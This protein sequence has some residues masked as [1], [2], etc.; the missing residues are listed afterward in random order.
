ME[1]RSIN[2][3]LPQADKISK[4]TND[5]ALAIV[6]AKRIENYAEDLVK[7][8]EQYSEEIGSS[9]LEYNKTSSEKTMGV[10]Y[11]RNSSRR[12][13]NRKSHQDMVEGMAVECGKKLGLNTGVIRVMARNHDIRTY[14]FRTWWRMVLV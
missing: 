4:Y 3:Q 8:L 12:M 11:L 9:I 13:Q 1:K 10:R 7:V 5:E 2:N 14:I 6:S